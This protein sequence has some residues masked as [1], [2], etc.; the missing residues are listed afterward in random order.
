M[1][2]I[3]WSFA[4]AGKVHM[5]RMVP[6]EEAVGSDSKEGMDYI[7]LADGAGSLQH[8]AEG[9]ECAIEVITDYVAENFER[10]LNEDMAKP[11]YYN[12]SCLILPKKVHQVK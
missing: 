9:A 7:V 2:K 4:K 3:H 10:L 11:K 5:E 12:E 8:S 1:G 6:C